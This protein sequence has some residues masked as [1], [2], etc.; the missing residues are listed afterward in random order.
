MAF[1][2]LLETRS[3][4]KQLRNTVSSKKILDEYIAIPILINKNENLYNKIGVEISKVNLIFFLNA[5]C[6]DKD[7]WYF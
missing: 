5:I 1:C 7:F 6:F 3:K 2:V 4:S